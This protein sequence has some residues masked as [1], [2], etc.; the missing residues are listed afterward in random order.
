M[1]PAWLRGSRRCQTGHPSGRP[2][3]PVPQIYRWVS[4]LV[5]ETGVSANFRPVSPANESTEGAVMTE[6][7][8]A[9]TSRHPGQTTAAA[10][11]IV[12]LLVGILGFIPGVTTHY[13]QM[14]FAGQNS[15][16]MLFGLFMVSILHNLVH[17]AFGVAGLIMARTLAGA[18]AFL[19]G[20]G[21]IY[22]I[23]WIYGLVIPKD[24]A[25]NF[26]P[27]NNADNWLHLVLAAG[28]ILLGVLV[29]RTPARAGAGTVR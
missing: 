3:G 14:S 25:A 11:G 22:A 6:N 16:A 12:F 4:G 2:V 9:T 21:I 18:R 1:R 24:S 10:V 8:Q 20:G 27:M 28:M 15:M 23:L 17:L 7:L 26:V 29:T 13:D 5:R 19:I